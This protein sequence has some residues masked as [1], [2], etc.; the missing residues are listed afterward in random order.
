[1]SKLKVE[2]EK[3]SKN[4]KKDLMQ[5]YKT[6]NAKLAEYTARG[7]AIRAELNETKFAPRSRELE[8]MK[9]ALLGEARS[10]YNQA[11]LLQKSIKTPYINQCN[12]LI[13]FTDEE[14]DQVN[15]LKIN[16]QTYNIQLLKDIVAS[17][18]I[19]QLEAIFEDL[20]MDK[21]NVELFAI[22]RMYT[23]LCASKERENSALASQIKASASLSRINRL[24]ESVVPNTE[25]LYLGDLRSVT[26]REFTELVYCSNPYAYAWG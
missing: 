5:S 1:M 19:E 22:M 26:E 18:T 24:I 4:Q 21:D 16:Q 2:I 11:V 25:R 3:I 9:E 15:L 13:K 23:N 6:V 7:N 20:A 17:Q 8:Q 14:V 10:Y 12:N